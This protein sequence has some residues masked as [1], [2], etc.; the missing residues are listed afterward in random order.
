LRA[1]RSSQAYPSFKEKNKRIGHGAR[2]IH[3][4]VPVFLIVP[5]YKR[6]LAKDEVH[7]PELKQNVN[8]TFE[9]VAVEEFPA[10]LVQ[11]IFHDLGAVGAVT[12]GIV[13]DAL[14]G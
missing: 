1:K 11:R 3:F 4:C 14:D 5:Q 7:F 13:F 9:T 8:H 2:D 10:I 12:A 6:D